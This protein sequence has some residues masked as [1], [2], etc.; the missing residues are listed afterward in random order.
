MASSEESARKKEERAKALLEEAAQIR[1]QIEARRQDQESRAFERQQKSWGRRPLETHRKI[2]VGVAAISI[3]RELP[4]DEK[5]AFA[6]RIL[7]KL[8]ERDRAA[9]I[10]LPEFQT[11]KPSQ[12]R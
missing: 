7:G 9:L 6:G 4:P 3:M 8:A 12:G 5:S 11:F 2:L 1:K 10:E